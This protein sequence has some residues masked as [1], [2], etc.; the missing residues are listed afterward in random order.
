MPL[1]LSACSSWGAKPWPLG[2]PWPAVRLAPK[3]SI[4]T[5]CAKSGVHRPRNTSSAQWTNSRLNPYANRHDIRI[6]F[7]FMTKPYVIDASN[8]TLSLG[9]GE[10]RVDI[11]RGIDLR[12]AKGESVAL[13]GPS[14]SGKSSLMAVLSG[15]ERATSGSIR[16]AGA[17]FTRSE[18]HPSELQSL[19][20]ISYAVFCW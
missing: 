5:S 11:L 15:L 4:W 20:R 8:V 3:A 14:G 2:S 7:P 13:L 9:S 19:M 10:A 1:R 12:V 18:E 6:P 16:V 17:D